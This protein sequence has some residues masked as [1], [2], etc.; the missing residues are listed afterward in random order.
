MNDAGDWRQKI[1]ET[2]N[3]TDELPGG[4]LEFSGASAASN[5]DGAFT[6][7]GV[8]STGNTQLWAMFGSVHGAIRLT[9]PDAETTHKITLGQGL[10][11]DATASVTSTIGGKVSEF[12]VTTL[13][14]E[15]TKWRPEAETDRLLVFCALW[16]PSSKAFLEKARVW[17]QENDTPIELI[18]LDWN[19]DQTRREVE[20]QKLTDR[21]LFAG[22]G[23][24]SLDPKWTVTNGQG[25]FLIGRDGKLNERPLD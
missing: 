10:N 9:D 16:H 17:A 13:D 8:A 20:S 18:S 4:Q 5:S 15:T 25:A 21:T 12:D 2:H 3:F 19:L 6:L 11:N 7:K 24:L 23:Q 22:P 1:D 14:G